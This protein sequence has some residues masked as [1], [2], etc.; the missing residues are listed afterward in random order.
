MYLK[1]QK[2]AQ[3]DKRVKQ[4][5]KGKGLGFIDMYHVSTSHTTLQFTNYPP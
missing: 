4:N 2:S 3:Q 5:N 1:V